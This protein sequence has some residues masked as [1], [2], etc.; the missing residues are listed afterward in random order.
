MY[1]KQKSFQNNLK[2]SKEKKKFL[3][4]NKENKCIEIGLGRNLIEAM[5]LYTSKR[6]FLRKSASFQGK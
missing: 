6:L 4:Q 1:S 5:L 3:I 2:L